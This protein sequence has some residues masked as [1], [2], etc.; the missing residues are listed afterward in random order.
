MRPVPCDYNV[1][2]HVSASFTALTRAAYEH[3]HEFPCF[4][5]SYFT[6]SLVVFLMCLKNMLAGL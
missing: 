1:I 5:S 3:L 2:Q 6:S 4:A